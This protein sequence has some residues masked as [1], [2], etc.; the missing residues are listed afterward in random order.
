MHLSL[1]TKITLAVS[2]LLVT[3]LIAT[4]SIF[5]SSEYAYLKREIQEEAHRTLDILD[6]LHTQ[7]MLTRG[8]TTDQ[9]S[10]VTALNGTFEQLSETSRTMSLWLVMSPKVVAFQTANQSD[11]I[12][13][14]QDSI[15]K[16]AIDLAKPVSRLLDSRL[17]RLTRPVILGEGSAANAQCYSCHRDLMGIQT[18]EVIGAFSIALDASS[19]WAKFTRMAWGAVAGTI[20]ISLVITAVSALLLNRLAGQ[21]LRQMTQ[22]M[23]RLAAGELETQVPDSKRTDEIGDMASALTVFKDNAIARK[24]IEQRLRLLTH[25]TEQSE[26][27]IVITDHDGVILYVNKKYEEV[28]GYS[29]AEVIGRRSSI[30]QSGF[31]E[32]ETY[33][34]MW[35]QIKSGNVWRVELRNR[36]RNGELFWVSLTIS[37][38][39]EENGDIKHFVAV[40]YDITERKEAEARIAFLA[41]NDPLTRLPNRRAFGEGLNRALTEAKRLK[42]T[43]A[44]MFLDLNNFKSVNDTLGHH[45]GDEL[46]QAVSRRLQDNLRHNDLL[47]LGGENLSRIGGDEFTIIL[48]N[49]ESSTVAASVAERL[50]TQIE[51]PFLIDGN[52]VMSG[53]CIGIAL[54]PE[55]G[56]NSTKLQKCA[57][58]ALYRA[59]NTANTNYA[60]YTVELEQAIFARRALE[61]DLC[62]ALPQNQFSLAYQPQINPGNNVICG[63]EALLRWQH[64][65]RGSVSPAEFIPIAESAGLI[66]EIGNWVLM[67]ACQQI[68]A[69]LDAGLPPITVAVNLSAEQFVDEGLVEAVEAA[70]KATSIP[71]E[72][73]HLEITESL[74]MQNT[75]GVQ[76]VLDKLRNRQIEFA[77]DDFGTGFSSLSYLARFPVN[78]IKLDRSFVMNIVE[79][80]K[81]AKLVQAVIHLGRDLGLRVN[82]EGAEQKTQVDMLAS[83]GVD[84]IQGFYYCRPLPAVELEAFIS[85][86]TQKHSTQVQ[87]EPASVA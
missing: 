62:Q 86:F 2:V 47:G 64:P 39:R 45:A 82:V 85:D 37:P 71:P 46:L 31:T 38:I 8:D 53:T 77:L 58:M 21:P 26:S 51:K 78:K 23:N 9:N 33:E 65:E 32:D 16:E 24:E 6:A 35:E 25:A 20:I 28:T 48:P 76:Q 60:F 74:L 3:L 14:P 66:V 36:K 12:E 84:E 67:C 18:G 30:N 19:T 61:H 52:E 34:K 75:G 72:L 87:S 17:F 41:Y 27:M 80:S 4:A 15:D 63:V 49:L 22:V 29:F 1:G 59:K 5:I 11:E 69:W 83:F 50:I 81:Q 54:Y 68:R 79:D 56:D 42:T 70:L 73:L 7:V 55:D 43:V 44:L 13:P 57:D 40:K 10:A